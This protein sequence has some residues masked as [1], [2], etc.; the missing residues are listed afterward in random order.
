MNLEEI[1][2]KIHILRVQLRTLIKTRDKL[3]N[4][5][6]DLK[7]WHLTHYLIYP[8]YPISTHNNHIISLYALIKKD[9]HVADC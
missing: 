6:L 9:I 3:L 7:I 2:S 1:N 4:K 8:F 5:K